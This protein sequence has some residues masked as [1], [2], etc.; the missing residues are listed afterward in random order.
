MDNKVLMKK[1]LLVT[2]LLGLALACATAAAT[3]VTNF[4]TSGRLLRVSGLGEGSQVFQ[5]RGFSYSNF[6]VGEGPTPA[7]DGPAGFDAISRPDI[8]R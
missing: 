4:T 3:P 6:R 1:N 7:T 5:I 2:F 8:C